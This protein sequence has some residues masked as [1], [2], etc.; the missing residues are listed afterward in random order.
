MHAWPARPCNRSEA[1]A[2]SG[3]LHAVV[4]ECCAG[5]TLFQMAHNV[6]LIDRYGAFALAMILSLASAIPIVFV[7]KLP[8][9]AKKKNPL[10]G[11]GRASRFSD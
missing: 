6:R 4:V 8:D 2:R 9:C 3:Y 7:C 1:S 10:Q 11:W 5:T